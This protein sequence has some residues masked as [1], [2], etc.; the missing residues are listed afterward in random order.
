MGERRNGADIDLR[1]LR[2]EADRWMFEAWT[3]PNEH[4]EGRSIQSIRDK[5]DDM[6]DCLLTTDDSAAIPNSATDTVTTDNRAERLQQL[7]ATFD[8]STPAGIVNTPNTVNSGLEFA[9]AWRAQSGL[10]LPTPT[11]IK[12]DFL[13]EALQSLQCSRQ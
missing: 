7:R 9:P 2:N 10:D 12:D 5:V 1:L 11:V 6:L 4:N 3:D 8:N 13:Y